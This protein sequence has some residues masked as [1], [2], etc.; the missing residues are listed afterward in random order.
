MTC[1]WPTVA[2]VVLWMRVAVGLHL[3]VTKAAGALLDRRRPCTSCSWLA[4]PS[5][6]GVVAWRFAQL[7]GALTALVTRSGQAWVAA[8]GPPRLRTES[9]VTMCDGRPILEEEPG[10]LRLC[11][12]DV[13][14][15]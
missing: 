2:V 5:A 13:A 9:G 15:R 7:R 6:R 3:M 11:C 1:R 10:C 4:S 8:A 12:H 14:R